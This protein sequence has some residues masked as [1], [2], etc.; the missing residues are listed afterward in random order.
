[1]VSASVPVL[2]FNPIIG[3]E[4]TGCDGVWMHS[5]IREQNPS[6]TLLKQIEIKLHGIPE[7]DVI[8]IYNPFTRQSGRRKDAP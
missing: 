1:M 3:A 4:R 8:L 6:K 5:A 7:N 2:T